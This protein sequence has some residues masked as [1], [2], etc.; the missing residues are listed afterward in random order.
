MRKRDEGVWTATDTWYQATQCQ[1]GATSREVLVEGPYAWYVAAA[2]LGMST[3]RN[4]HE[5]AALA[6]RLLDEWVVNIGAG[7]RLER[8]KGP[9]QS[10]R[11]GEARASG[12]REE[13]DVPVTLNEQARSA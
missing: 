3:V 10:A 5:V 8:V 12:S 6:A 13:S 7:V 2:M 4:P 9:Q 1:P 11:V